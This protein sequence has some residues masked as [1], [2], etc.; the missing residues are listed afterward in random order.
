MCGV[1]KLFCIESFVIVRVD[2]YKLEFFVDI[3]EIF[4][5]GVLSLLWVLFVDWLCLND[6][7]DGLMIMLGFCFVMDKYSSC[8]CCKWRRRRVNFLCSVFV[9]LGFCLVG[10]GINYILERIIMY[11]Y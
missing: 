9:F 5:L 2:N 1:D 3:G 4:E 6:Y 11:R 8:G 10:K 7:V